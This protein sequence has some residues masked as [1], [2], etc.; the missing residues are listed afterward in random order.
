MPVCPSLCARLRAA[1]HGYESTL[2]LE[3]DTGLSPRPC[4]LVTRVNPFI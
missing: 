3:M 4:P 2:R 1:V